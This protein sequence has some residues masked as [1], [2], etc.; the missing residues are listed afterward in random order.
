MPPARRSY[1]LGTHLVGAGIIPGIPV[2]IAAAVFIFMYS[3]WEGLL[4][5]AG[6]ERMCVLVSIIGFSMVYLTIGVYALADFGY[7]QRLREFKL[8]KR[9]ISIS[10]YRHAF[11][12]S[13]VAF[14]SSIPQIVL[15]SFL[16]DHDKTTFE[17]IPG[18]PT[19]LFQI[20][21]CAVLQEFTFYTSHRTLH[22]PYLYTRIHKVHHE[23]KT[24]VA[25]VGTY[26]HPLEHQIV[27]APVILLPYLVG[28]HMY[29]AMWWF[30]IAGSGVSN[31]HSGYEFPWMMGNWAEQH[32]LHH[33]KFNGNYGIYGWLDRLCGTAFK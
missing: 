22:I 29:S 7:L 21:L 19:T 9:D 16:Q 23:Y 28:M 31:H 33:L 20:G 27:S 13:L 11:I 18:I 2:C 14:A 1:D 15:L 24:P 8:Q 25:V 3:V 26:A 12:H 32:D 17:N 5:F 6:H 4:E 30:F 10:E